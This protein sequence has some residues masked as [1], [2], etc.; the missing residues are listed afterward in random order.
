MCFSFVENLT[1]TTVK[2]RNPSILNVVLKEVQN[3]V[4]INTA[5]KGGDKIKGSWQH[6]KEEKEK[7]VYI[8]Y[9]EKSN[10]MRVRYIAKDVI[11]ELIL[12]LIY[13]MFLF[14]HGLTKS[15]KEKK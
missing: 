10:C 12:E 8:R 3:L 5:I 1:S 4:V 6:E 2:D 15:T 9:G 13:H 11:K 14:W 7:T